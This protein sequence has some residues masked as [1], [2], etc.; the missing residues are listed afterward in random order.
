MKKWPFLVCLCLFLAACGTSGDTGDDDSEDI[1]T[2]NSVVGVAAEAGFSAF[3]QALGDASLADDFAEGGPYT[4]FVPTNEAFGAAET[5]SENLLEYH[6]VRGTYTLEDLESGTLQTESGLGLEVSVQGDSV[7]LGGE[8]EVITPNNLEADNG[9]VHA[10]NGVL[11]PPGDDEEPELEEPDATLYSAELSAVADGVSEAS[12]EATATLDG[13]TLTVEGSAQNLSGEITQV[14]LYE[15]GGDDTGT[16]FYELEVDGT[17]FN[18]NFSLTEEE[19]EILQDDGFYVTVSTA[20]Y[21]EGEV[22]GPLRSED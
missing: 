19:L 13:E 17:S 14:G 16:L 10:I 3:V 5:E 18:G 4:L 22:G 12:G 15:G 2:G 11:T 8:A 20:A 6:I 9:V 21:P 1:V 7:T